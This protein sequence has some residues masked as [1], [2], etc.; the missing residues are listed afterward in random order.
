M[1][2]PNKIKKEK[3]YIDYK[4]RGMSL[5]EDI[6]LTNEYYLNNDIAVIYKKPTPIQATE[7]G[8]E[9]SKKVITKGYFKTPST[10]DYNGLYNG[11]YIDFEAKETKSKTAFPLSNI[12]NHQLKHI[13]SVIRH[14]GIAFI[15][16]RFSLLDTTYLLK[17]D[18][19][20]NYISNNKAKSIPL[21]YIKE[22]GIVIKE[23]YQPRLDYIKIV[24]NI[25]RG[26]NL[27]KNTNK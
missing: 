25:I 19:L 12:H 17:G 5:E 10:T 15:I 13:E 6:N 3:T 14:K 4:N 22:Y 7:V 24:D 8:F 20:I 1:N 16:I 23:N 9:K 2:Y 26:V 18:D 27:W 11:Y 21:P